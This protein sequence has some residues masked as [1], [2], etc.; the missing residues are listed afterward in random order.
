MRKRPKQKKQPLT[1]RQKQAARMIFEGVKIGDIAAALGVNRSTIW[2]WEN[3]KDFQREMD[4]VHDKWLREYRR[5]I[6]RQIHSSPE[7]QRQQRRKYAARKRLKRIAAKLDKV[8]NEQD[9][10]KLYKQ[11]DRAY[12]EAYFDGKTPV[13]YLNQWTKCS[14]NISGSKKARKE[15]KYI[16]EI[17]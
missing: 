14:D 4:R 16:I 13:E 6:N 11:F 2:R 1:D 15:P 9:Y 3:R 10:K 17:L 12:N 5:E 7:Y 8:N